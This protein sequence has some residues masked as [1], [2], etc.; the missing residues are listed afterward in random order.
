MTVARSAIE[1]SSARPRLPGESQPGA[2]L[3]AG[4]PALADP[5]AA[6]RVRSV[7]LG[8]NVWVVLL[9]LPLA[10][11]GALSAFGWFVVAVPLI[12]LSIGALA[13]GRHGPAADWLLLGVFPTTL[14]GVVAAMPQLAA[15]EPYSA[16]SLVLGAL[17]FV[18][19]GAM[20]AVASGRPARLRRAAPT[21][22]GPV[23]ALPD[24]R[25]RVLV[26]RLL[27]SATGSA[28]VAMGVVI[29]AFI[30]RET[31]EEAWGTSAPEATLLV[32][33]VGG[34]LAATALALFVGP[35]LRASRAR[36][37]RPA[38]LRLRVIGLLLA[39][40]LGAIAYALLVWSP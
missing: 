39:A 38:Q 27:L 13:L 17:S 10:L 20:I 3:P 2:P 30:P 5:V 29:P 14:A 9:V 32:A 16:I 8:L 26:R 4:R 11:A 40:A 34:A 21:P 22:L 25:R 23:P 33:V 6:D 36:P 7:A 1:T 28:A 19:Y 31:I 24:A 18:A 12:P 15:N 37:P 35:T